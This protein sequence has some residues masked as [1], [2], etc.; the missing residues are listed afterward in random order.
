MRNNRAVSYADFR[1]ACRAYRPSELLPFLAQY[2]AR[3]HGIEPLETQKLRHVA[4]WDVAVVA[5]ENL[6]WGNE[7]RSRPVDGGVIPKLFNLLRDLTHY[8][9]NPT[10]SE[11]VVPILNDQSLLQGNPYSDTSRTI[12]I[13]GTG[14][15]DFPEY[16]WTPAF[17]LTL[18]QMVRATHLL[19]VFASR[20]EGRLD[21]DAFWSPLL[22]EQLAPR[23]ELDLALKFL[24]RTPEQH[25]AHAREAG[26]FNLA[27]G[28]YDY[29]PL[30]TAPF[31]DFG[32]SIGIIAP[33][34]R[35]VAHAVSITNLYFVGPK[36]FGEKAFHK[37]LGE[38]VESYVGRQL[39]LIEGADVFGEL[40]INRKNDMS[41]DWFLVLPEVIVLVECKSARLSAKALAGNVDQIRAAVER[42]ITKGREQ[43]DRTAAAI[44]SGERR[45]SRVPN[46]GRPIL[47]IIV[48]AESMPMA[49]SG[50]PE[51]GKQGD[52]P[53]MVA[54]V[55]EIE[56]LVT[57][58]LVEMGPR[59]IKLFADQDR[60]TW[61]FAAA[62]GEGMDPRANPILKTAGA[63][64]DYLI[65]DDDDGMA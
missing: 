43:I 2:S 30:R 21:L 58:P 29:N 20:G 19:S 46:D 45:L 28:Q 39:S 8:G 50:M 9:P 1:Q 18:P 62:L 7:H 16:D 55:A 27:A 56:A 38:R 34:P 23:A 14:W 22:D 4:P 65:D 5:R 64:A 17:G 40:P 13:L 44:R 31:V 35:L 3:L 25:K 15:D 51:Y 48:T 37:E 26:V 32:P 24:T 54:T 63:R 52:I 33:E 61:G 42:Y 59:L 11:I 49:N 36:Y 60:R 12:A 6:L 10:L 53:T 47:G 41:M 57:M